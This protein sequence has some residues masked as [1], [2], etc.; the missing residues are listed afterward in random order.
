MDEGVKITWVVVGGG[1]RKLIIIII[2]M[3]LIMD[4]DDVLAFL[5]CLRFY[6]AM[7][8]IN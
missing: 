8:L 6:A 2:K 3:I 5:I 1:L 7:G 4:C